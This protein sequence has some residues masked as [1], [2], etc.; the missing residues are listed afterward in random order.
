MYFFL[1][2]SVS[3]ESNHSIMEMMYVCSTRTGVFA[4]RPPRLD[5]ETSVGL[6]T[7]MFG[8]WYWLELRSLSGVVNLNIHVWFLHVAWFPHNMV[9]RLQRQVS[10]DLKRERKRQ[11]RAPTAKWKPCY[12]RWP[13]LRSH[14]ASLSLHSFES[15]SYKG[16][17]SFKGEEHRPFL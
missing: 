11:T 5:L 4:G 13:S 10:Q 12:L 2:V 14:T 17:P 3:E 1:L 6:F 16:P 9:A 15:D 7:H 8:N